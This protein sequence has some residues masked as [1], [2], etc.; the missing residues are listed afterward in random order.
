M[1]AARRRTWRGR[2]LN[3]LE[4][5]FEAMVSLFDYTPA[6]PIA[7]VLYT[8]QD[9]A[10]ITRAPSWVGALNDGRI[11]VPV[12]GLLTVTPELAHV[13]RHELAHSFI[14]QKTHGNCA[15]WLQE[16][17]AQWAEGKRVGGRCG[18]ALDAL[19]QPRGSFAGLA[20][21]IVDGV[22]GRLCA[23]R[24]WLVAGDRRSDRAGGHFRRH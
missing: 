11:R 5:D 15:I 17:I 18:P 10:D 20:G 6:E 14:S 19:R 24:V 23:R 21:K 16:G 12:Q 9:F 7:V 4:S 8:N 22:A 13:L 2:V 1:T 3:E